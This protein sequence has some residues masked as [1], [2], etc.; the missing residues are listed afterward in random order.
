MSNGLIGDDFGWLQGLE[1]VP[2]ESEIIYFEARL[3]NLGKNKKIYM[4]FSNCYGEKRKLGTADGE[5][6]YCIGSKNLYLGSNEGKVLH[7]VSRF[8]ENDTIGIGID[9]YEKS[10]FITK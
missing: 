1:N 4:G 10:I 7:W 5:I 8:K 9:V 3:R 2:K 6:S